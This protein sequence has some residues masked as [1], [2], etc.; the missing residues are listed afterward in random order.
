MKPKKSI[1]DL[2]WIR[3]FTPDHIPKRLVEQVTNRDYS[4]DDFFKYQELSCLRQSSEGP[5]LNPLSHLYVLADDGNMVQGFLW[6]TVDPLAKDLVVQTFSIDKD[7]WFGGKAVAKLAEHIKEI[8]KKANL[9]KVYWI[10]DY[11]KH[12]MRYGFRRSDSV[13]MEYSEE[14][15]E[16]G[17]DDDGKPGSDKHAGPRTT[18][19]A[20]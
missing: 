14:D 13:L 15:E 2:K 1:D 5:T 8:R 17:K 20:E 16:D 10:T 6:F 7:Y 18:T 4:V 3:V 12:S 19:S 11:P 9:N